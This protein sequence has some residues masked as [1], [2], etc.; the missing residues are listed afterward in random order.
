MQFPY[1]YIAETKT[2]S[3]HACHLA[4]T[5]LNEQCGPVPSSPSF[6]RSPGFASRVGEYVEIQ[7]LLFLQVIFKF[8]VTFFLK[9]YDNLS[10]KSSIAITEC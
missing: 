2:Y 3:C 6:S 1:S 5:L 7:L 9:I 8:R 4:A 10:I